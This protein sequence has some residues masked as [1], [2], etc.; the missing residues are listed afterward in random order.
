[1]EIGDNG[2]TTNF[3][4]YEYRNSDRFNHVYYRFMVKDGWAR[5]RYLTVN[6][7]VLNIKKWKEIVVMRNADDEPNDYFTFTES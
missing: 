5:R 2:P 6:F 3:Y 1:V 7:Q 4:I